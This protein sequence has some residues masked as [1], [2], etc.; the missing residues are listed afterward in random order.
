[1]EE[2][3]M[4]KLNTHIANKKRLSKKK[5]KKMKKN[6]YKKSGKNI[7]KIR[8]TK[9]MKK[10]KN[11]RKTVK[12][13][14]VDIIIL[15][16]VCLGLLY[17]VCAINFV[18]K[19]VLDVFDI[20]S[21]KKQTENQEFILANLILQDENKPF[22]LKDSKNIVIINYMPKDQIKTIHI[23]GDLIEYYIFKKIL[24][25]RLPKTD[26]KEI[27]DPRLSDTDDNAILELINRFNSKPENKYIVALIILKI[28]LNKIL[29]NGNVTIQI[30]KMVD[31]D[32]PEFE[33]EEIYFDK[34][35][36]VINHHIETLVVIDNNNIKTVNTKNMPTYVILL[37]GLISNL[38]INTKLI[39]EL[40]DRIIIKYI[41]YL[42]LLNKKFD[43]DNFIDEN[44]N[45]KVINKYYNSFFYK[46]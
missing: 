43:T 34:T 23:M 7:N 39:N 21:P 15:V 6:T 37:N 31:P 33:N 40:T 41:L 29:D 4:M 1:M 20:N 5:Y 42:F 44:I 9:I 30:D 26:D 46:I 25:H 17:I 32:L 3:A 45:E 14:F 36:I 12:G 27:L 18:F 28:K 8:K 22:K 24:N 16:V 11:R 19:E 38:L 35:L 13:G 10:I 2:T